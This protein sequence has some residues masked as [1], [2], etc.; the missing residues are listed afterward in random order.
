MGY[1][2]WGC[3]ESGTMDCSPS[4]SSVQGISR[5]QYWSGWPFPAPG[6]LPDPEIKSM[7][8][9]LH[10]G[11]PWGQ[12]HMQ[13]HTPASRGLGVACRGCV[14]EGLGLCV[15]CSPSMPTGA[16][17]RTHTQ[18]LDSP[19]PPHRAQGQQAAQAL[20]GRTEEACPS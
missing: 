18:G 16:H 12:I 19:P 5:Q 11:S 13:T 6:D 10:L 9:A 4:V 15:A 20:Q 1:S 7:S 14:G 17:T 3:K 8:S 2:L